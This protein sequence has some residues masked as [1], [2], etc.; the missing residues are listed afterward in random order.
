MGCE[1]GWC[2]GSCGDGWLGFVPQNNVAFQQVG[3]AYNHMKPR[4]PM[5]P[6]PMLPIPRNLQMAMNLILCYSKSIDET[7]CGLGKL[8]N[9]RIFFKLYGEGEG[10]R[11]KFREGRDRTRA[12]RERESLRRADKGARTAEREDERARDEI[13]TSDLRQRARESGVRKEGTLASTE[14]ESVWCERARETRSERHDESSNTE[15]RRE[16]ERDDIAREQT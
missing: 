2:L 11:E 6:N 4:L 15:S 9:N 14:R 12:E 10:D 3:A 5:L 8:A 7:I 16:R 13:V 1:C